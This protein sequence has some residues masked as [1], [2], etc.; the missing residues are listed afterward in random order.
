MN[1]SIR[2]LFAVS[3]LALAHAASGAGF[4]LYE[5]S[6]RGNVTPAAITARGEE[7][8]SLYYNPAAITD[9]PGTQLQL[10]LTAIVPAADVTTRRPTPAARTA[11]T[12]TARSGPSRTPTSRTSSPT[13]GG[14]A[15]ASARASA[16][17]PNS[18][19][20]G[21]AATAPTRPR[22]SPST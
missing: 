11:P 7:P 8:G 18:R 17:A 1:V 3:V 4:A 21:P 14:S 12:A 16:S 6:A 19:R 5:G 9:L 20:H 22:S 13:T 2:P 10:G 15:S